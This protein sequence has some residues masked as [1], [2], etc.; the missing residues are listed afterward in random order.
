MDFETGSKVFLLEQDPADRGEPGIVAAPGT[1]GD[2]TGLTPREEWTADAPDEGMLVVLW[3]GEGGGRYRRWEY[4]EDLELEASP[5]P[6]TRSPERDQFLTDIFTTA[7]E[8]GIQYW[9]QV[10]EYRHEE[11]PRAVITEYEDEEEPP[12]VITLDTIARGVSRIARA[13]PNEIEYLAQW[14][15]KL[16]AAASRQ[17]R[18]DPENINL[19]DVRPGPMSNFGYDIDADVADD[20]L[21]V[22]LFGKVVYG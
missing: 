8:G 19:E 7:L 18:T 13:R 9:A 11:N 16:V 14:K 2:P 12:H 6:R 1:T 3:P 5:G 21:Q 22:A 17:N 10:H 20:I 15:R 4:P